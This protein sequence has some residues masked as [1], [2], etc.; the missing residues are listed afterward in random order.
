V[1]AVIDSNSE[2]NGI[3]FP[4]PGNDDAIRAINL[5]CE[6]MVGAVLDGIQ[7][8]MVAAG[9]DIGESEEAPPEDLTGSLDAGAEPTQSV[10]V[11]DQMPADDA[12]DAAAPKEA[13]PERDAVTAPAVSPAKVDPAPQAAPGD[14]E[15]TEGNAPAG[16]GDTDTNPSVEAPAEEPAPTT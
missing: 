15:A 16:K 2:P 10:A 14:A 12:V 11:T 4:V 9:T 6:L 3:D 13:P 5:Y 7:A 1:V 8:E